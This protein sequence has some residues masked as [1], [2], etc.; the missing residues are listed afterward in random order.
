M[1]K[2]IE[3]IIF[4][5]D[6]TLY[7]FSSAW[8][9]AHEKIFYT[10]N[11]DKITNYEKF[12]EVFLKYDA[13]ILNEI[14]EGKTRIREL[15]VKRIVL[16]MAYFGINYNEDEAIAFY[17]KMFIFIEEELREDIELNRLLGKLKERYRLYLLTNGISAEQRKKLIKLGL[18]DIFDNIYISSETMIN[19]PRVEAFLNVI[20]ENNLDVT[21]TL[22]IGDSIHHDIEPARKLGLTTCL[23]NRKWHLTNVPEKNKYHG[24]STDNIKKILKLL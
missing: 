13:Q 16:T 11:L 24:Y 10:L 20:Q 15:R 19:K 21:T 7:D 8:L 2:N 22:M 12:F 4:D 5:L 9:A 3:A 14:K 1:F 6:N 17:K 18:I 23:I